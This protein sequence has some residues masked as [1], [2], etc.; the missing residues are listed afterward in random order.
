M[1]RE[2]FEL[3]PSTETKLPR[4]RVNRLDLEGIRQKVDLA[5]ETE[6]TWGE[7]EE[8]WSPPESVETYNV[9]ADIGTYGKTFKI[10]KVASMRGELADSGA[11]C[12]MTANLAALKNLTKLPE[13]IIIGL[14]I[15]N[16]GAAMSSSECTHIG[17]LPVRCD[18]GSSITTKCFYNPDASDTIISPQA[19]IDESDEFV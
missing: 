19:I 15:S 1:D 11:N 7:E 6:W 4:F 13:P 8:E 3:T 5:D 16:D 12:S 9:I 18:D 2:R 10:N 14:A 17:D